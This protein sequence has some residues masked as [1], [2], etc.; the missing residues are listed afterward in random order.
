MTETERRIIRIIRQGLGVTV[1][2]LTSRPPQGTSEIAASLT[3][4]LKSIIKQLEELEK[5]A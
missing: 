5:Q 1:G 3:R 4:G 2:E